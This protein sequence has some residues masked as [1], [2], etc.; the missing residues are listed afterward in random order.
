MLELYLSFLQ[1][2]DYI[3]YSEHIGTNVSESVFN[4][5]VNN[6]NNNHRTVLLK[7]EGKIVT[8]GT[9]FIEFK[10]THNGCKCGH[11]ENIFTSVEYRGQGLAKTVINKLIELAKEQ[12]CYRVDIICKEELMT[13]YQRLGFSCSEEHAMSIKF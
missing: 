5:F 13:Y 10:L 12:K 1:C 6:Q 8:S 11:I 2:S 3:D 4:D 9:L 7:H